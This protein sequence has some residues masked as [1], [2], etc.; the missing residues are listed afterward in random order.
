VIDMRF[1]EAARRALVEKYAQGPVRLREAWASVPEAARQWRPGP[2][3]WSAHEVVVH[4]ADSETNAAQRIRYVLMEKD[5]TIVGYDQEAWAREL[6]YH[7]L[8]VDLALETVEAVRANTAAML[9]RLPE[10]AW[11]RAGRHTEHGAYSAEDWLAIYAEHVHKHA[12]QIERNLGAWRA[13]RV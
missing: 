8:P 4:C 9:R 5:T 2:G 3:K 1:D 10:S 13:G 6:D 12:G 7:S 11:G